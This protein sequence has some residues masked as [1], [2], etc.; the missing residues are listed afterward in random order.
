MNLQNDPQEFVKNFPLAVKALRKLK[1]EEAVLIVDCALTI[2]AL[3]AIE[4]TENVNAGKP[5][6]SEITST[7]GSI[8][9]ICCDTRNT[10]TNVAVSAAQAYAQRVATALEEIAKMNAKNA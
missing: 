9:D 10:P 1:V 3:G 5:A 8:L 7:F 4:V 2:G 6:T